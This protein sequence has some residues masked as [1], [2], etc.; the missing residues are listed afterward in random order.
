[1]GKTQRDKAWGWGFPP[2]PSSICVFLESLRPH[3]HEQLQRGYSILQ[4][5]GGECQQFQP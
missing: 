3:H 1:M 4:S 5:L 2:P